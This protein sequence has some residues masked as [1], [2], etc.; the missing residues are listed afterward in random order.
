MATEA[1]N[2]LPLALAILKIISK[3]P[4]IPTLDY[5]SLNS[6]IIGSGNGLWPV[7][8]QAIVSTNAN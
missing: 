4:E 7:G 8:R 5:A 3:K 1:F 2:I 6:V